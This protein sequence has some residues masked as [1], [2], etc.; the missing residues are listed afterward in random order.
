MADIHAHPAAIIQHRAVDAIPTSAQDH[1]HA[2]LLTSPPDVGWFTPQGGFI[3][4]FRSHF[5]PQWMAIVPNM[6]LWKA[7]FLKPDSHMALASCSAY[8]NFSVDS[9]R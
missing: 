6:R 2:A 3:R 7:T 1:L 5:S 9:G 4:E 8:R